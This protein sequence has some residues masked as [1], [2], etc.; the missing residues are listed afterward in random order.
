MHEDLAGPH[1][2]EHVGLLVAVAGRRAKRGVRERRPRRLAQVGVA[3]EAGELPQIAEIEQPLDVVDL[4]LVDAEPVEQPDA[5]RRV[6]ACANLEPHDLAEAPPAQLGLDRLQQ[7][8]GL[9]G[10]LEVGVAGD[11]EQ[12]VADDVHAREQRV[13]MLGDHVLERDERVRSKLD[14]PRDHVLGH[15]HS[16][17]C[18]VIGVGIVEAHDQAQRQVGDVGEG[19]AGADRE[20]RQDREDLLAEASLDR[21]RRSARLRAGDDPDP[22][23]GERR[24]HVVLELPRVAAVL[25]AHPRRDPLE[26]RGR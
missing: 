18:V 22:V 7:I 26:H 23:L 24:A 19:A 5:Q 16:R 17:E 6:H 25:L 2:R 11:A 14:E 20:R 9:V 4:D 10:D 15:L 8:V 3:V 13:E 21:A 12:V 1:R